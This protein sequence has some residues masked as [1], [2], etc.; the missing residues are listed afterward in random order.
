MTQPHE[1]AEREGL[2]AF[3]DR[4]AKA[5]PALE[6]QRYLELQQLDDEAARQMTL[7]LFE[8]WQ[9]RDTDEMGAGLIEAQEV[10]IELARLEAG[11]RAR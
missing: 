6:E 1:A 2:Q 11:G 7:D 4:W 10:F 9:P 5:G 8:I 3:V